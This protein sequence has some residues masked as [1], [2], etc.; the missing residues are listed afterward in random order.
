MKNR[1]LIEKLLITNI[2]AAHR[3][4]YKKHLAFL[5][6]KLA[7]ELKNTFYSSWTSEPEKTRNAAIALEVLFEFI[8]EPEIKALAK[9]V[10]AIAD[11]TVGNTQTAIEKL[12]EAHQ[13]FQFLEKPY[14]AAQTQVSKIYAL[15]L[16]GR[17][18]EAIECGKEALK[19]FEEY[20]DELAAGKIEHNLGNIYMRREDYQTSEKFLTSACKRFYKLNDLKQLTMAENALAI[21][22]AFQ[23]KFREAEKFYQ[24]ALLRAKELEMLVTQAEI[25]ASMGNLSLFRGKFDQALKLLELSRQKYEKLKMPHQMAVAELEVA[26]AYLELNLVSEAFE[27]YEKIVETLSGL[28]MQSE[29]A[30]ARVNL[31]RSAIALDKKEFA[32]NELKKSLR[33]Y[34][35]EKN[36]AGE[37]F[38]KL[39]ETQLAILNKKYQKAFVLAEQANKLLVKSGNLRYALLA[40]WLQ[41]DI[42]FHLGKHQ[43]AQTIFLEAFSEAVR[44]ENSTLAQTAQISLGRLALNQGRINEAEKHF[45]KAVKLIEILREPLPAED[46]RIAFL[47]DKLVPYQELAKIYL[48]KGKIKEA[49]LFIEQSRSRAL[50][51][52]LG[53]SHRSSD[54]FDE[55]TKNIYLQLA[56]LREE[57]N[58]YY[59]RLNRISTEETKELF[60]EA[61]IRE[62][63]INEL[64]RQISNIKGEAKS[65]GKTL[66]LKDLQKSLGKKRAL[67]EYIG[68]DGQISVF[69]LTENKLEFIENLVAESEVSEIF[70]GLHFQFETMRYGNSNLG[71][72]LNVLKKRT[73]IYLQKLYE[74]LFRPLERFVEKRDVAVVPFDKLHY[75]PFHALHNGFKYLV[76]ERKISFSPSATVLQH[77]LEKEA[78]LLENALL[79]GFADEKIPF[80]IKEIESLKKIFPKH[81]ILKG[82]KA[83]FS[84]FKKD[85]EKFDLIHLACHGQFRVDNPMFSSLRLADSLLTVRDIYE[86]EL[87]AELVVLSACETGLNKVLA[88]EELLGLTR[89][90]LSAGASSLILTLWTVDDK[91]TR[92]L[93]IDF[94]RELESGKSAVDSLKI[95]QNNLI[96][97]NAHPYYW[98]SFFLVGKW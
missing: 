94:Y 7:E 85:I 23:N 4:L 84:N 28:K 47:G 32:G 58:W 27:S 72:F 38:V 81:V 51:E 6:I 12:A 8:P 30:R 68:F 83:T 3:L 80:A 16:P 75:L 25:E 26:D 89:G 82:K 35:A 60:T 48:H 56:D 66:R 41:G 74:K 69:V 11:L 36:L 91:T 65:V 33:L 10:D 88:G 87:N 90:F 45:K 79:V 13:I 50:T 61:K 9:W 53:N 2:K 22:L 14:Q 39:I 44:Q 19:I 42:L 17:Y 15:A 62:K 64:M 67:I 76:E 21:I 20:G 46:F 37:S 71:S 1:K 18:D 77:C 70:E 52:T 54:E 49:F 24:K 34:R 96:R 98:S 63:K 93:M 40:K 78:H 86:L 57:L 59:S 95:A 31:A 29:E 5:N 97:Q 55:A 73:D 43:K 92:K